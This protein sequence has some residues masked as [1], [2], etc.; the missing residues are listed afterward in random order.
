M[1]MGYVHSH[2]LTLMLSPRWPGWSS[3]AAK[4]A[5]PG[6]RGTGLSHMLGPAA[7]VQTHPTTLLQAI[8]PPQACFLS[9][10]KDS[11]HLTPSSHIY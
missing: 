1:H 10:D 8:K 7:Q 4:L 3:W 2:T 11:W 5:G 9:C 6:T